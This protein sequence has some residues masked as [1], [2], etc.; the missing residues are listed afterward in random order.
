MFDQ[1]RL[2]KILNVAIT[3][4]SVNME[5]L[6]RRSPRLWLNQLALKL[7]FLVMEAFIITLLLSDHGVHDYTSN[8]H[9]PHGLKVSC[10]NR[11][12]NNSTPRLEHTKYPLHIFPLSILIFGK[13]LLRLQAR[14]WS[15]EV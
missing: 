5:E 13:P 4:L 3:E 15:S 7:P 10:C 11:V 2:K 1:I 14:G 8:H 12:T 6:K 9:L